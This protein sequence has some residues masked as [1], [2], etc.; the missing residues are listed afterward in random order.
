MLG[1]FSCFYCKV[2]LSEW[3]TVWN[4]IRT[5]ILLGPDLGSNCCKE[6]QHHTKVAASKVRIEICLIKRLNIQSKY[7]MISEISCHDCDVQ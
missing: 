2:A 4:Q 6:Y 5:D 1:N 7:V 3:N